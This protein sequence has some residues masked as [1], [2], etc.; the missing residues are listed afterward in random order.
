MPKDVDI[1]P[2]SPEG[3]RKR[4]CEEEGF[5]DRT[6]DETGEAPKLPAFGFL[7]TA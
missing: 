1:P 7:L 5:D 6:F 3:L 4:S 2:P